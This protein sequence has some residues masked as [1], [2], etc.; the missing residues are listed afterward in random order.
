MRITRLHIYG[1]G[2][3]E[4]KIIEFKNQNLQVIYGE[5]EAGK[6]TLRLFIQWVLFG[7]PNRSQ[8]IKRLEPRQG[9]RLGGTMKLEVSN[10]GEIMIERIQL[11]GKESVKVFL[12]DGTEKN[13]VFLQELIKGIDFSLYE[14]VFSFDLD[15]LQ[16]IEKIEPDELDRYLLSAGMVGNQWL[17]EI[18]KNI[19]KELDALFKPSGK[20]PILNKELHSIET[21]HDHYKAARE[22]EESYQSL[23]DERNKLEKQIQSLYQQKQESENERLYLNRLEQV[24]PFVDELNF[25]KEQLKSFLE[26]ESFPENG[27]ERLKDIEQHLLPV[28]AQLSSLQNRERVLIESKESLTEYSDWQTYEPRIENLLEKREVFRNHQ[29]EIVQLEQRVEDVKIEIEQMRQQLGIPSN[30]KLKDADISIAQKDQVK[31]LSKGYD[32]HL[33]QK[34]YLDETFQAIKSKLEEHEWKADTLEKQKLSDEKRIELEKASQSQNEKEVKEK[35]KDYIYNQ[36][37]T[38]TERGY[39]LKKQVSKRKSIMLSSLLVIWL[40]GASWFWINNQINYMVISFGLLI[41]FGVG[42]W[43][44]IDHLP[45]QIF[46]DLSTEKNRLLKELEELD[47]GMNEASNDEEAL[48][49][50]KADDLIVQQLEQEKW[51][52]QQTEKEFNETVEKFQVWENELYEFNNKIQNKYRELFLPDTLSGERLLDAFELLE[53]LK[54]AEIE[55][56]RM[57]DRLMNLKAGYEDYF[58]SVK[59][60]VERFQLTSHKN[61]DVM[62]NEVKKFLH[63]EREK[64]T[65]RNQIKGDLAALQSEINNVLE[66][67]KTYEKHIN[68]LLVSAK[69]NDKE[70]FIRNGEAWQERKRLMSTSQELTSKIKVLLKNDSIEQAIVDLEEKQDS[71]KSELTVIDDALEEIELCKQR[72][73]ER[74]AELNVGIKQLE[75]A[76]TYSEIL[77]ELVL[78]KEEFQHD[79]K[80]WAV[81]QVAKTVLQ[82]TKEVYRNERLPK[83]IEAAQEY[84]KVMTNGTYIRIFSPTSEQS[85]LVERVDGA[86]FSPSDL[87]RATAEQ[88]Y[89]AFRF[90]LVSIFKKSGIQFP[91]IIDDSFVNFDGK[92]RALALELIKQFSNHHQVILFTCHTTIAKQFM[93]E[94]VLSLQG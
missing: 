86:R 33:Q 42:I 94:E 4:N 84:F 85:M 39:K 20:I 69:A 88:L 24:Q 26:V 61:S 58:D 23:I 91:I 60:I 81:Y 29:E 63:S 19:E 16:A 64:D 10:H 9:N 57:N 37:K 51:V 78:K 65:K 1:F 17:V 22:K 3:F 15:G 71:L 80:K 93:A 36:T 59:E 41:V 44:L 48:E 49:K 28:E 87:S 40:G 7:A 5:N 47:R 75:E 72:K 25:S 21:L 73:L 32:D 53:K 89:L 55:K 27:I 90:A 92:R 2:S 62:L 46:K 8:F 77:H 13:Q 70:Q 31:Q 82:E 66:K 12:N 43:K 54:K 52:I 50:I 34:V 83:V 30:V 45:K 79:A 6:S 67:M 18:E 68:E 74:I 14:S 76:G 38:I 56:S 35:Q 11:K